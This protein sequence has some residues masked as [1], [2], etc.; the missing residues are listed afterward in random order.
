MNIVIVSNSEM[1]FDYVSPYSARII[2][3]VVHAKPKLSCNSIWK[4]YANSSL[5][6]K[7]NC[8][9]LFAQVIFCCFDEK[10]HSLCILH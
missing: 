7:L 4:R 8:L 2:Q 10:G 1:V 6:F 3:D 5:S 9:K